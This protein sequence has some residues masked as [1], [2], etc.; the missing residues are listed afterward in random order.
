MTTENPITKVTR[1]FQRA[2]GSE[3]K[4]VVQAMQGSGLHSSNDVTVFRRETPGA[5]WTLCSDRPHPDWRKMSVD[6]YVRTGRSEML[7]T[8]TFAEI[9]TLASLLGQPLN[10]FN[11]LNSS[12]PVAA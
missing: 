12:S 7:E 11:A 1:I 3:A 10:V 6:D 4:I 9:L 8:V 5:S 2:D